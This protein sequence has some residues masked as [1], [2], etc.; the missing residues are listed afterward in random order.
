MTKPLWSQQ[1]GRIVEI[2][3]RTAADKET[4]L[5]FHWKRMYI[6]NSKKV[7]DLSKVLLE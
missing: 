6:Q 1:I 4:E 3:T 2:P 5:F 7:Q